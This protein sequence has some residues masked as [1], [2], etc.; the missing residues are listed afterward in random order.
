MPIGILFWVLYVL[1]VVIG[2]VGE[3]RRAVV[4]VSPCIRLLHHLDSS[5]NSRMVGIWSSSEVT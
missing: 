4:V 2:L 3:L 1:S 5:G